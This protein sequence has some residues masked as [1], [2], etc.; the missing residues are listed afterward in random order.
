MRIQNTKQLRSAYRCYENLTN[1]TDI[2]E[3]YRNPSVFKVRAWEYCKQLAIDHD[4]TAP[5]ILGHNCMAFSVGFVGYIDGLKHFFCITKDHDRA[6]PLE[7]TDKETGEV[8]DL[9]TNILYG[10]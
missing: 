5:E 6:L 3:A 7:T 1:E 8:I 4:G 2:Y 9:T 10:N